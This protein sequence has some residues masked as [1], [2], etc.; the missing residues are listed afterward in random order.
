MGRVMKMSKAVIVVGVWLTARVTLCDRAAAA[1][2]PV[3]PLP[4]EDQQ[5]ITTLFGPGVVGQALPSSPI[6]DASVYFPLQ[7]RVLTYKVTSGSKAGNMQTL[8]VAKGKRPGGTPAWRFELS[9][10][11][12]GF[13]NQGPAGDLTMPAISDS[14][15]GVV[16]ITTPANPFVLNGMQPGETRTLAQTVSVNYLDDPT[17]QDYSGS[18]E[19]RYTYVGTYQVTVP[20]G[21]Y[22]AI[23]LRL[24]YEG[25]VGP[26]KTTDTA[27]Y[28]FAPQ[29]GVVALISQE[30]VE[31]FW[32]V[33]IDTTIAKVLASVN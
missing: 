24:K 26:A 21:T 8:P 14:G 25:K 32:V 11:L 2:G 1:D 17:R 13:I 5:R 27:Y 23:L 9:P 30:D 10:S 4:D 15:E 7:E 19:S 31:A 20:A 22:S 28:F 6:T 33:H 16:V 3:L 29:V 18:L 12:A